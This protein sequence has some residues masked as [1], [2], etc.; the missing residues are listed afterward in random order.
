M[1]DRDFTQEMGMMYPKFGENG[2]MM[3]FSTELGM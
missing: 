1:A 2:I 3:G